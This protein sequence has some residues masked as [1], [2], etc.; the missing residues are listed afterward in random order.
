MTSGNAATDAM[1]VVIFF[2]FSRKR[3]DMNSVDGN[4]TSTSLT[5]S[6][7]LSHTANGT[8]SNNTI[9]SSHTNINTV[10]GI[11]RSK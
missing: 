10:H 9:S 4:H 2:N 7:Y 1:T 8:F 11:L 5:H 3:F 6:K